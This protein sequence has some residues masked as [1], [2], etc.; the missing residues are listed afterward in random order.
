M[1]SLLVSQSE[2]GMRSDS[3]FPSDEMT[4]IFIETSYFMYWNYLNTMHRLKPN[5]TVTLTHA[6]E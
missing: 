5:K 6:V 1:D 4:K 3:A 2:M